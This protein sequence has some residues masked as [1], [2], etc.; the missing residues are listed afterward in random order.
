MSV[1]R[2]A[3]VFAV[4]GV[5]V[6]SVACVP[7]APPD[8]APGVTVE[9]D[10]TIS[11]L[12]PDFFSM[13]WPNEIRTD[14]QGHLDLFRF[15]G[16]DESIE[17]A[18]LAGQVAGAV[19][20]FGTQTAVYLRL[21]G[22]IDPSTLPSPA[23]SVHPDSPVQLVERD[24]PTTRVPVIARIEPDDGFRGSNLL[25][26]LPYPGHTMRPGTEYLVVVTRGLADPGG[27][28]L[29]AARLIGELDGDDWGF[30]ARSAWDWLELRSQRDAAR[31]ALDAGGSW[32]GDDLVGFT[33]FRTQDATAE[34]AA[35]AAAVDG[36]DLPAPELE[37]AA[38]QPGEKT[39]ALRGTAE[40]PLFQGGDYPFRFFGGGIVAADGV[41][42]VQGWQEHE[43]AL[44]V[45]CGE[46]PAGG[47][48]IQTFIDGTGGGANVT[49]A[50]ALSSRAI[51]GSVPPL[52]GEGSPYVDET[53]STYY[54]VYN[55]VAARGNQIQQAAHNLSLIRV[56]QELVLEGAPF[57]SAGPVTTDDSKISVSGQSQGAQTLPLVA[58]AEPDID[59]VVAGAGGA[60]YY[61]QVAY[62]R[63]SREQLARYAGGIEDYDIRN[64]IAQLVSVLVDNSE[65][66]NFPTEAHYLNITGEDDSCLVLE[67]ARHLAGAQH[68]ALVGAGLPS[69]FGEDSLEPERLETPVSG[70][71]AGRTRVNLELPGGHYNAKANAELATRFAEDALDGSTPVVDEPIYHS[72]RNCSEIRYGDF[73]SGL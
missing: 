54:N 51:M 44:S 28:P 17:L 47:W 38:C 10:A 29:R 9:M 71:A 49:G 36:L 20:D 63:S 41:A 1:A 12:D 3:V 60:G 42:V 32:S 58:W 72:S 13:P 22:A 61:N 14:A 35:V 31:Q 67:S 18:Y 23:E 34:M 2:S 46:A 68:L 5:V 53:E 45:P 37:V 62:R 59:A 55:P 21:T 11:P 19:S 70:N 39:V 57:G 16:T 8:A 43:M 48:P 33:G 56:L 64:P 50:H 69:V 66:A 40:L 4:V 25:S 65:A 26:L 27:T 30:K 6:G 7:P 52:Y 24:D 15:P 73:A